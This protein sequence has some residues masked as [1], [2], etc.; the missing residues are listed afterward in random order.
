MVVTS[1]KDFEIWLADL[2]SERK[3]LV[4]A[5][6]HVLAE[7]EVLH[8]IGQFRNRLLLDIRKLEEVDQLAANH[9]ESV[10]VWRQLHESSV[11]QRVV[12]VPLDVIIARARHRRIAESSKCLILVMFLLNLVQVYDLG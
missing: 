10:T 1:Q 6:E 9:L 4:H 7:H 11:I 3:P 2:V 5:D 8:C 12:L